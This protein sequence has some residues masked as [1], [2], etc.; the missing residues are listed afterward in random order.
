MTRLIAVLLACLVSTGA[1]AQQNRVLQELVGYRDLVV[2]FSGKAGDCNLTDAGMF[3]DRLTEKLAEIGVVQGD[4]YYG[5]ASLGISAKKF[6]AIGGH[7]VTI[8]ELSFEGK[9]NKDNIVTSDER[10]QAAVDRMGTIPLILYKD[11]MFGVQP[12][13]QPAAGG[14][15]TTSQEAALSMI[16]DLVERIKAKRQ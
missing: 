3:R 1:A 10:V 2:S 15:S 12:Q 6:G 4:K 8:V 9:L 11:G 13:S 14:P 5:V 7:C 16:G